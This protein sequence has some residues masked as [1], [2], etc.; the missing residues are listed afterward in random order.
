MLSKQANNTCLYLE[1][2]YLI[3]Y[4]SPGMWRDIYLPPLVFCPLWVLTLAQTLPPSHTV[5]V[6]RFMFV[7]F[8]ILLCWEIVSSV[9]HRV[10]GPI[11]PRKLASF[12]HG[13]TLYIS[14]L[15]LPNN[16]HCCHYFTHNEMKCIRIGY[17][18]ALFYYFT[19]L[20]LYVSSSSSVW[21]MSNISTFAGMISDI[22][23]LQNLQ[24]SACCVKPGSGIW[25][26]FHQYYPQN[27]HR[28]SF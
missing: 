20:G 9:I 19:W 23:V 6:L 28:A 10:L 11:L 1:K 13:G 2:F 15:T 18:A 4:F 8:N 7:T 26:R 16:S 22:S 12:E 17:P 25:T 24:I 5:F 14:A 21:H 27:D 3:L